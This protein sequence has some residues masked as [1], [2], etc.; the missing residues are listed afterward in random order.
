[1]Q[2]EIISHEH[3]AVDADLEVVPRIG[4]SFLGSTKDGDAVSGT[5]SD[6]EHCYNA[7]KGKHSIR[8][9]LKP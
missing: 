1:M 5:V 7:A 3:L 4:E 9:F 2:V 8:V 6:I